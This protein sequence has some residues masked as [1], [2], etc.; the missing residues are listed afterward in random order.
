MSEPE[1][2]AAAPPAAEE[3]LPE[4]PPL[5]ELPP[6]AKVE[7]PQ[8]VEGMPNRV[9]LTLVVMGRDTASRIVGGENRL[10]LGPYMVFGTQNAK[11]INVSLDLA[12]QLIATTREQVK[13]QVRAA[14]LQAGGGRPPMGPGPSGIVG[15]RGLVRP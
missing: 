3:P 5:P 14:M 6:E 9:M 13:A 15:G 2:E 12:E 11:E 10:D 8:A 7:G 4:V 1:D